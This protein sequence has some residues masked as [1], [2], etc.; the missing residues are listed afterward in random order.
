MTDLTTTNFDK[1]LKVYYTPQRVKLRA[2]ERNPLLALMPKAQEFPGRN[3]PIPIWYGVGQGVSSTFA[4]AQANKGVGKYKE[5]VLTRV[6]GY[7]L[8]SIQNEVLEAARGQ[9]A[10]WLE[11]TVEIDGVMHQVTR[12]LAIGMYRDTTGARGTVFNGTV[13][14]GGTALDTDTK[15][16]TLANR[17]DV[18]NFEVGMF[19]V[20]ATSG[21]PTTLKNSGTAVSVTAIDRSAG[22]LTLSANPTGGTSIAG[23]DIIAREGD[24]TSGSSAL[25]MAGLS[26]WIPSTAPDSTSFFGVDRSDDTDRLGGVRVD[27][28]SMSIE[29]ALI[30]GASRLAECGGMPDKV[31]MSP[32]KFARLVRELGSKVEHDIVKSPD[33]AMI[34]FRSIKVYTPVG[35][36]DVV[37]DANCQYDTAWMLQMDT[38][39][40][41]SMGGAPKL[42]TYGPGEGNRWV[43]ESDDDSIE[44]RC[45]WYGNIGCNYPGGNARITLAS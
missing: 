44:F 21:A 19:L 1:A 17:E 16:L 42:L 32:M 3:L 40:L 39:K 25:K 26:A 10:A 8:G 33:M 43:R 30:E 12:D 13:A 41:Y 4:T 27:G 15:I 18:T 11:A 2:Y 7:G 20:F 45:G 35:V 23:A 22:T 36:L 37:S 14:S 9:K 31:F 24:L 28:T 6:K 5:F 34:G 29:D 38:W